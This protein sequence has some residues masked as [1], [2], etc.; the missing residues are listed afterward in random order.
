MATPIDETELCR[1]NDNPSQTPSLARSIFEIGSNGDSLGGRRMIVD[2][3]PA[4]GKFAEDQRE[5]A[6]WCF[7][8]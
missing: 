4:I 6:M 2:N 5:A 1:V 8:V 7:S 3:L